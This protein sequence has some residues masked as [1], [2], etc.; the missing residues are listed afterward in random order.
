MQRPNESKKEDEK[1]EKDGHFLV[2]FKSASHLNL[3]D[4]KLC[5]SL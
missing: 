5:Y 2:I 3:P 1:D 4:V